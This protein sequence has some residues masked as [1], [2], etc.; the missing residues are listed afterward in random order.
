MSLRRVA[1]DLWCAEA[2]IAVAGS[3]LDVRMTVVRG[4]DG[5][6]IVHSPIEIDDA[7]AG[8][9]EALGP[10]RHLL[11]PSRLHHLFIA[12]AVARWP[13]AEL[14]GAPGLARKRPELVFDGILGDDTPEPFVGTLELALFAGAPVASEVVCLHPR[15]RT[16]IV[17]DLV[18]NIHA[19][20]SWMSRLY[21]RF[22]GAWRKVAQTPLMRAVVRDREAARTSLER[23]LAWDFDRLI[24][25][26]GEIV[27]SGAKPI[28]AG[29]L[30]R[31]TGA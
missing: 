16:L 12:G 19:S 9:V 2:T 3:P 29:A 7:L 18:F 13:D 8:A 5:G 31:L 28:L 21:L 17:T 20:A 27:E 1:E 4:V 26:H 23:V 6:L 24:M 14:W 22:S 15:S 11:A 30:R 10:I 25:A